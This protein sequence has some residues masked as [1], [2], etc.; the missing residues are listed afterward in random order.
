MAQTYAKALELNK[1]L[2][3]DFCHSLKWACAYIAL[4]HQKKSDAMECGAGQ[5]PLFSGQKI[6][7]L[8][9]NGTD[10]PL[11]GDPMSWRLKRGS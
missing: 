11:F 6:D 8:V 9:K 10:R 2:R 7:S 4:A 5:K 1:N 3:F